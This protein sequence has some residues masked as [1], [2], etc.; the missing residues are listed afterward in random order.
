MRG[1]GFVPGQFNQRVE[2]G[3]GYLSNDFSIVDYVPFPGPVIVSALQSLQCDLVEER[4]PLLSMIRL[5]LFRFV[6]GREDLGLFAEIIGFGILLIIIEGSEREKGALHG[7]D[8]MHGATEGFGIEKDAVFFLLE[9]NHGKE[10]G[11]IAREPIALQL[12]IRGLWNHAHVHRE[13]VIG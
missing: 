4:L 9:T 7:L 10:H 13:R 5:N 3:K 2:V 12:L 1:R 11:I 8:Q 6:R